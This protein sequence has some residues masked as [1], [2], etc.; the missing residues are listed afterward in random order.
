M[1]AHQTM[2][3]SPAIGIFSPS[4]NQMNVQVMR[5]RDRT[6][7]GLVPKVTRA[8]RFLR[9]WRSSIASLLER[10]SAAASS[11]TRSA[12]SWPVSLSTRSI[13]NSSTLNDASAVP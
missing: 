13:P 3:I 4:I 12:I 1:T 6:T 7:R 9:Q 8:L 2:Q 11:A 5:A 10:R